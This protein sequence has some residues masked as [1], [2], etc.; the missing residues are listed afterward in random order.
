MSDNKKFYTRQQIKRDTS[1]NWALATN[2]IPLDGEIIYYTDL[3]KLKVGD[4]QTLVENLPFLY[5]RVDYAT[6]AG[7]VTT[8]TQSYRLQAYEN[9]PCVQ[10]VYGFHFIALG[11]NNKWVPLVTNNGTSITTTKTPTT[12]KFKPEYIRLY[13]ATAQ[14]SA[15]SIPTS[16]YVMNQAYYNSTN[17]LYYNFYAAST[18]DSK[19]KRWFLKGQYKDGWFTLD[20][21]SNNSWCVAVPNST[22][23]WS[24]YFTVGYYYVSVMMTDSNNYTR[25]PGTIRVYYYDGTNL[26]DCSTQSQKTNGVNY[27]TTAPTAANADGDIKFV[28]LSSEPATKYNG[29]LYIITA[30]SS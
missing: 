23:D 9:Y 10:D 16:S 22:S 20:Q 8:A 6:S 25:F 14:V 19:S 18:S 12:Y 7:S 27:L 11:E 17:P 28:V 15:G 30:S 13:L 26:L 1:A 3:H 29:Y 21:A 2:F 24:S 5:S 4:G